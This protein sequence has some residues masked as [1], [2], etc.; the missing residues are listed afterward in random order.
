[1]AFKDLKIK[2]ISI[3]RLMGE[4]PHFE[5]FS[6]TFEYSSATG[7]GTN[8]GMVC[9]D[10]EMCLGHVRQLLNNEWPS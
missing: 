7:V 1:M 4:G 6:L 3:K 8:A 5:G 9:K 2:A 10:E